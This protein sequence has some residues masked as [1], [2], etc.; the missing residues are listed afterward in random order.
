MKQQLKPL[1][2]KFLTSKNSNFYNA[3]INVPNFIAF[4]D[5]LANRIYFEQNYRRLEL[6]LKKISHAK[7][8]AN[9][10]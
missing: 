2:K 9:Y 6:P 1:L 3:D 8:S 5:I 4:A 7:Q 10:V